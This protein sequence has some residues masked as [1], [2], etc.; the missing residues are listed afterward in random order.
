MVSTSSTRTL[1]QIL[2]EA[3]SRISESTDLGYKR[4]LDQF[5]TDGTYLSR[6]MLQLLVYV[7]YG[8]DAQVPG[9]PSVYHYVDATYAL[10]GLFEPVSLLYRQT[11]FLV[12]YLEDPSQGNGGQLIEGFILAIRRTKGVWETVLPRDEVRVFRRWSI[13]SSSSLITHNH[14]SNVLGVSC[15]YQSTFLPLHPHMASEPSE[16]TLIQLSQDQIPSM[17]FQVSI[18]L[19]QISLPSTSNY[20]RRT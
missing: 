2:A 3:D 8:P 11:E 6:D 7:M 14:S 5:E 15:P 12:K 10:T 18:S 20:S 17:I 19:F 16:I 1:D 9:N 13:L 4:I